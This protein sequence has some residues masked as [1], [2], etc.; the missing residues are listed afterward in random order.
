MRCYR[1]R[2]ASISHDDLDLANR[3]GPLDLLSGGKAFI[4]RFDDAPAAGAAEASWKHRLVGK[5]V[6]YL[7]RMW[8]RPVVRKMNRSWIGVLKFDGWKIATYAYCVHGA[9]ESVTNT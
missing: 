9:T 4:W 6:L 2:T 8:F 5:L 3:C 7:Q 1:F